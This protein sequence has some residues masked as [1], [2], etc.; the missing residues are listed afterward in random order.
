MDEKVLLVEGNRHEHGLNAC[1]K[2]LSLSKSTWHN[3]QHRPSQAEQDA[4]LKARIVEVIAAHPDYGYR[5][6]REE[7]AAT[8]AEPVNHKQLRRVLRT[9]ELGLRRSL[10]ATK[11]GAVHG[12]LTQAGSARD[13]VKGRSFGPLEAFS[14][15][16]T[17]I[18]YAHGG[19]RAWLMTLLC[20]ESR[21]AGGWAVGPSRNRALALRALDRLRRQIEAW[22]FRLDGVVLHHDRDSVYTSHAWLRRVLIEERARVS[23]AEHGARDNPW[24]ESFWG[25]FKTE[26]GEVLLAA[27]TLEEVRGIVEQQ[28]RYYN[29]SRRHSALA[30]Q[31]P[32]AVLAAF[33]KQEKDRSQ[34]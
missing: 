8:H 6:I 14:T 3:R 20:L 1:L 32:E 25:R 4:P 28:M 11:P 34:R 15:D 10:P 16:L 7:L 31:C 33:I 22:G 23:Y 17:A 9:Y 2:A 30:Y 24:I 13:L 18:P 27:E 26:N 21:W 29:G 12:L 5:R 19:Q